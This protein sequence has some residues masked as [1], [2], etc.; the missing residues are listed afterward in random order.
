[1]VYVA[2]ETTNNNVVVKGGS[3]KGSETPFTPQQPRSLHRSVSNELTPLPQF[4]QTSQNNLD[5]NNN[6]NNIINRRL[7]PTSERGG[8]EG[9]ADPTANLFGSTRP[10]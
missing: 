5:N 2:E 1:M 4:A 3:G 10:L 9:G 7:P 8:E 6:N